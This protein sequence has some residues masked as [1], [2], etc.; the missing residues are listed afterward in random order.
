MKNKRQRQRFNAFHLICQSKNF[1]VL[2]QVEPLFKETENGNSEMRFEN[3]P[4]K[5]Q[6]LFEAGW[7]TFDD[8]MDDYYKKHPKTEKD[9]LKEINCIFGMTRMEEGQINGTAE[10]VKYPQHTCMNIIFT[11]HKKNYRHA[12]IYLSMPKKFFEFYE[13]VE[14]IWL[15][16][17]I[18]K[19]TVEYKHLGFKEKDFKSNPSTN[20]VSKEFDLLFTKAGKFYKRKNENYFKLDLICRLKDDEE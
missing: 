18:R 5:R 17:V 12:N 6:K 1:M 20:I 13:E 11:R 19:D 2:T 9:E 4:S 3:V 15:T 16:H 14:G 7:K 8:H 10:I